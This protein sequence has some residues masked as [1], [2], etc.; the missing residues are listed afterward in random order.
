MLIALLY[1]FFARHKQ[2]RSLGRDEVT[3]RRAGVIQYARPDSRRRR[4]CSKARK[5]SSHNPFNARFHRSFPICE[6]I[7]HG[8]G[9][10]I[11]LLIAGTNLRELFKN[12]GRRGA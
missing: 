12:D 8:A 5:E 9:K 3:M 1:Q 4:I 11:M 2:R 7:A 10:A 6:V